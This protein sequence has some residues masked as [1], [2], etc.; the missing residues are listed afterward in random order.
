MSLLYVYEC[1]YVYIDAYIYK[2]ICVRGRYHPRVV[3]PKMLG[4]AFCAAAND[5]GGFTA[6]YCSYAPKGSDGCP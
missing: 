1:R 6:P 3:A 5:H 2:C 4:E